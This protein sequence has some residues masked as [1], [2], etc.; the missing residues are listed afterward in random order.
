VKFFKDY[1]LGHLII[2]GKKWNK[3]PRKFCII[4]SKIVSTNVDGWTVAGGIKVIF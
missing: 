3:S 2:N 1:R 4:L